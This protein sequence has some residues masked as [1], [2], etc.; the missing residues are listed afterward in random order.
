MIVNE[1][2]TVMGHDQVIEWKDTHD[3]E[4]PYV[5]SVN[6]QFWKIRVNDFPD[7]HLFTLL[8][9]GREV[10]DFD[11]WPAAWVRPDKTQRTFV[12]AP[13]DDNHLS[14]LVRS[15]RALAADSPERQASIEQI[16]RAYAQDVY[17]AAEERAA[18]IIDEALRQRQ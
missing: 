4:A 7:E 14:E 8:V 12:P 9:D 17:K 13:S 15:L 6:G 18:R 3:I 1:E 16:A 5:A 10:E 11:D 2:G